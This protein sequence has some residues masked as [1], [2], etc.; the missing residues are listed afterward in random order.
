MQCSF[1]IPTLNYL[2]IFNTSKALELV[3]F[4]VINSSR[5]NRMKYCR[6]LLSW[7]ALQWYSLLQTETFHEWSGELPNN[8][9]SLNMS[10]TYLFTTPLHPGL[11]TTLQKASVINLSSFISG[12]KI[13]K[14]AALHGNTILIE[15]I[16]LFLGTSRWKIHFIWAYLTKPRTTEI[17]IEAHTV[18]EKA[19]ICQWARGGTGHVTMT[20][21]FINSNRKLIN[22]N[23]QWLQTATLT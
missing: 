5:A 16:F 21:A 9:C 11:V 7:P 23:H 1:L 6:Y 8:T 3:I 19:N 4:I 20:A 22:S 10:G 18:A 17:N 14:M 15:S 13:T 12:G 2:C